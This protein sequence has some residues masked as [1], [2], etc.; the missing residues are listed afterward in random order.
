MIV[1]ELFLLLKKVPTLN[2]F[3]ENIQMELKIY[4]R[5]IALRD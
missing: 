4:N 1:L 3:L 2:D 5:R